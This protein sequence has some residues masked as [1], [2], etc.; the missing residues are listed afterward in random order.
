MTDTNQARTTAQSYFTTLVQLI[1]GDPRLWWRLSDA[2]LTRPGPM[3]IVEAALSSCGI[4]AR[5]AI[6]GGRFRTVM[7]VYVRQDQLTAEEQAHVND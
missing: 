7:A 4:G 3:R 6:E 2:E 1:E 5:G